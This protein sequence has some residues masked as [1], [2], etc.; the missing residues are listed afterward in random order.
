[1][2]AVK[3]W[4]VVEDVAVAVAAVTAPISAAAVG[5]EVGLSIGAAADDIVGT[6]SGGVCS[7]AGVELLR[8]DCDMMFCCCCCCCWA[9]ASSAGDGV[10]FVDRPEMRLVDRGDTGNAGNWC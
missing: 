3:W 1:M 9:F 6:S 5:L 4:P 10:A 8:G 7:D 2:A